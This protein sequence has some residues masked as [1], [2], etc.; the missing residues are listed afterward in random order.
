MGWYNDSALT[1]EF[2]FS[3]PIT[4]DTTL[5]AKWQQVVYRYTVTFN[6]N[7]GSNVITQ[8][9]NGGGLAIIPNNPTKDG[10]TFAGW[11]KDSALTSEFNFNTPI[12][13]NTTLYAK[14][15]KNADEGSESTISCNSNVAGTSIGI[16][17]SALLIAGCIIVAK[18]KS[19]QK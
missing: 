17:L 16:S 18:R 11:Y 8:T 14:W 19:K 15:Q 13:A 9:V 6:S 3:S 10:Y 5:Y 2:D 12:T 7:G 4:E 1:D